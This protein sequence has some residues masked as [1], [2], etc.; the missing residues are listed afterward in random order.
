MHNYSIFIF[1][2]IFSSTFLFIVIMF[3]PHLGHNLDKY[4][5]KI[6]PFFYYYLLFQK[7]SKI[8]AI[9]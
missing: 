8:T 5:V 4:T 1:I 6:N 9:K 7:K 3:P 2:I